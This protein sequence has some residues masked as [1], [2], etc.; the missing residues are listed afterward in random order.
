MTTALVIH[1]HFYQP[2]RENPR[3]ERVER[4]ASAHPFHDWNER[5]HSECYRPNAYARIGEHP[6][7]F[8]NNYARISFNFGPTLLSWLAR[9]HPDTYARII[10]ADRT[11]AV[12]RDGHG[13]ALA[14]GYN[15]V[16][17]PLCNERDLRTQVR[18][19]V[20]D[21][22]ARFRRAPEALW[23]PETAC[24]DRTLGVLIDEGLRYVILSPH[25]AARVRPL[26]A[27][28]WQNVEGGDGADPS[29]PYKYFHRDGSGRSIV[30][31]F[32]D[33]RI[34]QAI[35]FGGLLSSSRALVERCVS[36]ARGGRAPLVN[37]ATDGESYGHHFRF[38]EL[39]LAYALE[40]EAAAHGLRVTNYG[41]F[42]DG[43]PPLWEAE[44]KAGEGSAW[45][46][47]HGLG[48][49]T[50]DCGCRTGAREGWNQRWRTP[51]RAALDF[52]RDDAADKFET[53]AGELLRD[54]WE[55]RNDYVELLVAPSASSTEF[56]ARHASRFLS[57]RE[58]VRAL[59]L[60]ELQRHAM[61]MYTSC[62]WFFDDISGLETVQVLRYAGRALEL[63]DE[64]GFDAPRE[65][66]LEI[67]AGAQSNVAGAGNGADIFRR[68]VILRAS[69]DKFADTTALI[70]S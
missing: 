47:V 8:V 63:L 5:I 38:G 34:S 44:I 49:W 17:L 24:D 45:S 54:P 14:Q 61:T 37:V 3:T 29:V 22:S 15:H 51:L 41:E 53:A 58:R 33:G 46:C 6:A 20:R 32:Y 62:G 19:G 18:W 1:G 2:P 30:I 40:E 35:A 25:Q 13:N 28:A 59:R 31:F 36:A 70:V 7:R 43:H 12:E 23:L 11:S 66:F 68:E 16:I 39:C 21:F 26:G 4:E 64:L 9:A 48:R 50:R 10:E 42:L 60:L 69:E 57:E 56:L 27:Q 67:L 52:L 65:P 55:A